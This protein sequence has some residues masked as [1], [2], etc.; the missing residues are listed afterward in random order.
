MGIYFILEISVLL[1]NILV[2]KFRLLKLH[3]GPELRIFPYPHS[4][5]RMSFPC[6]SW[7]FVQTL[8]RVYTAISILETLSE[9]S[10]LLHDNTES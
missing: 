6:F 2:V 5:M 3:P 7:L 9:H 1:K 8:N 10:S 4:L